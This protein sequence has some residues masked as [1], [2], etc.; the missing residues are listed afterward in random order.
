M[1]NTIIAIIPLILFF[2]FW[3]FIIWFVITLVHSSK[4]RNE[5]LKEISRKLDNLQNTNKLD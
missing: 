1:I 5:L 4:E 2:A 3:I